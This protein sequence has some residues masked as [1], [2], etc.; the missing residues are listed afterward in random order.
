VLHADDHDT[1]SYLDV[2]QAHLAERYLGVP[3]QERLRKPMMPLRQA[4]G[5]K[6][7]AQRFVDNTTSPPEVRRCIPNI[8]HQH[9]KRQFNDLVTLLQVHFKL[10]KNEA[11]KITNVRFCTLLRGPARLSLPR[12]MYFIFLQYYHV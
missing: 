11:A 7:G 10:G 12:H 8:Y 9:H 2:C 5:L 4:Q 6:P 1:I 3:M